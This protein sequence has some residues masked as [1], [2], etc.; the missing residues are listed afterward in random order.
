MLSF[1]EFCAENKDDVDKSM[2]A[3][4]LTR[5]EA[6]LLDFCSTSSNILAA[7]AREGRADYAGLTHRYYNLIARK[8]EDAEPAVDCYHY[9]KTRSGLD[10]K[11]GLQDE[12]PCWERLVRQAI[13]AAKQN[14]SGKLRG[15]HCFTSAGPTTITPAEVSSLAPDGFRIANSMEGGQM[16]TQDSPIVRFVSAARDAVGFH[17]AVCLDEANCVFPPMTLF[18]VV[19]VQLESFEYDG[20]ADLVR[21]FE[22]NFGSSPTPVPST[23]PGGQLHIERQQALDF[24][25]AKTGGDT[26]SNFHNYFVPPNVESTIYTVHRT[27]VTVQAT[28]LPLSTT[29][30]AAA[31]GAKQHKPANTALDKLTANSTD[32]G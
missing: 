15:I 10:M 3:M 14:G 19:D 20:T 26:I 31:V 16:E 21:T 4:D 8:A 29:P 32:L 22:Y 30:V 12:E 28:F 6:Q 1:E 25:K 27:L 23:A 17:T 9:L 5:E 18:T 7:A 13:A 2:Q 11:L 24:F